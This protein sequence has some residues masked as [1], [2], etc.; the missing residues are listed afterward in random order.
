MHFKTALSV[1]LLALFYMVPGFISTK[2]GKTKPEHLPTLSGILLY[3]GTPF[4]VISSFLDPAFTWQGLRDMGLF[5]LVTL[6]V[7]GAFF[8]S[9]FFLAGGTRDAARRIVAMGATCGNVGFFGIPVVQNI[10]PDSPEVAC[11]A[12]CYTLSMNLLVFTLGIFCLT[13]DKK[14]ISLRAALCNP[15]MFGLAIGLPIYLLGL[16]DNLPALAETGIR[17]LGGLTTPLCMFIL[18]IRLAAT[19]VKRLFCKGK[20]YAV[21]GLKLVIYPLICWAISRLLPLDAAFK[22]CLTLLS[23]TPCAAIILSMAEIHKSET[24]TSAA[25]ILVSTLLCVVTIPLFALMI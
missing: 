11:Y 23:A 3:I 22:G 4:M 19:P 12:I 20:V 6:M 7:Q 5:F 16:S 10:F 14:Y 18:G 15:S 1:V 8:L 13:G 9:V 25:C 17:T 2:I 21:L 24:E